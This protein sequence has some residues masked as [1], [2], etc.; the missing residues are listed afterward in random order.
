MS[1]GCRLERRLPEAPGDGAERIRA[2][3]TGRKGKDP[4]SARRRIVMFNRVSA[5]GY[6]ASADGNLDWV[7]PEPAL[8]AAAADGLGGA[9]TIL[10]GRRTYDLFESFWPTVAGD[11]PT[12]PD[13]HGDGRHSKEMRA[14]ADW[15]NST[16]KI[17]FSRTRQAATWANSHI[18]HT[19]DPV[20]VEAM[21]AR[22][23]KDMMIFGS[24]SIVSLLTQH[25][26]IDEYQ[27]IVSP[28][29]LGSGQPLVTGV[30]ARTGLELIEATPFPS[31]N[32]R[33]RY[34]RRG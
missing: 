30:S 18:L 5:E 32:V 17:L 34:A 3:L 11:S 12:A 29:L 26:L 25:G 14:M 13:P 28:L 20:E 23:G 33:L 7:V 9:D 19:F 24:G 31:G 27:L 8:D 16:T 1:G 2:G 6:F 4:M 15:I 22:P 21:K 10:F